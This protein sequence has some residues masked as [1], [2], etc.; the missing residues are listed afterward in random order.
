[1]PGQEATEE[2]SNEITPIPALVEGIKLEG[3]LVSIDAMGCNP[4]H[5]RCQSRLP[6]G[7]ERQ[8][9]NP[10]GNQKLF[11]YSTFQ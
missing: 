4:E 10:Y 5:P 3:A 2:K 11:R 7:R 1:V 9:A 6:S 8:P